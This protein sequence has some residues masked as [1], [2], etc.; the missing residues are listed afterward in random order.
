M[1]SIYLVLHIVAVLALLVVSGVNPSRSSV[2]RFELARLAKTGDRTAKKILEREERLNDVLSLQRVLAALL[3]VLISLTGVV[4]YS[5]T[6]GVLVVVLFAFEAG[7]ISKLWPL[8]RMS[9]ALYEKSEPAI[10]RHI[11]KFPRFFRLIKGPQ[12]SS[13]NQR[14]NSKEELIYLVEQSGEVLTEGEKKLISGGLMFESK[15]VAD[16]MTPRKQIDDVKKTEILGPMVLND[17]HNMGHSHIPVIDKDIDHIVGIL[18]VQ[19]LLVLSADSKS[20]TVEKVMTKKV[21][22]IEQNKNLGLCL[23]GFLRHKHHL[24]VVVNESKETV[25]LVTLGD[26]IEA[27]AGRSLLEDLPSQDS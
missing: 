10:L 7:A 22:Y 5:F 20:S 16:I 19:D 23:A 14:L 12:A 25:G 21:Y 6:I 18:N 17:L 24:A 13:L 9:K 2:S 3:L 26:V 8:K 4:A 11:D 1:E 15:L 27:L